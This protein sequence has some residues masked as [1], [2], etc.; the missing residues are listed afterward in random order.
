MSD[1]LQ[2]HSPTDVTKHLKGI[3]FPAG[4]PDILKHAKQ[5]GADQGVIELIDKMPDGQYETMADVM[6]GVGKG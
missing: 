3:D 1:G 4:K 5:Q 6:K 2:G